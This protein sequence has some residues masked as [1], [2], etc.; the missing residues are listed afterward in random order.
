MSEL[1]LLH[2]WKFVL[3][4]WHRWL[5]GSVAF[6]LGFNPHFERLWEFFVCSNTTAS[7]AILRGD[8]CSPFAIIHGKGN[9]VDVWRYYFASIPRCTGLLGFGAV[10]IYSNPTA[11]SA[12]L[13]GSVCCSFTPIPWWGTFYLRV[14][15]GLCF[16]PTVQAIPWGWGVRFSLNSNHILGCP[17]R[18]CA[19]SLRSNTKESLTP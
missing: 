10:G 17:Q 13:R 15:F 11:S 19:F 2:L 14:A 4:P 7:S 8:G 5:C 16:N 9:S 12:V 3:I 1:L 18:S 6:V